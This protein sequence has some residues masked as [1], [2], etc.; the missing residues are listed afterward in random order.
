MD[1][2]N[3]LSNGGDYL[4][5]R[6]FLIG[7][8]LALAIANP[9]ESLAENHDWI[10]EDSGLII[11][12]TLKGAT[13]D[14]QNPL[15]TFTDDNPVLVASS[16]QELTDVIESQI[17]KMSE[18]ISIQYT[19]DVSSLS[20]QIGQIIRMYLTKNDYINGTVS[21]Y[22]YVYG[23][24]TKQAITINLSIS[25]LTTQTQE[26]FIQSEV[27]R[28][29]GEITTPTMS[30]FEKVKAVNDYIVLQSDYSYDT[31]TTP[32]SVYTLLN[33]GK[34]VCQA[35]ALL[36]YRLLQE[37]GMEVRYV[38]GWA[39]ELHAWNLVKVDGEWYH[40]DTTWNDP[41]FID[42]AVDRTDYISYKYFLIS[43]REI[44]KDHRI[45]K[46]NYPSATSDRFIAMRNVVTP[47]QI[48]NVLY[49][50]NVADDIKLYKIDFRKTPLVSEKISDIRVQYLFYGNDWL[51]F[52]NYSN[53]GYLYKMKLDGS[54]TVLLGN[55]L[56]TAIKQEQGD[57]VAYSN[58]EELYREVLQ[59]KSNP[60][61][62]Q[63]F[64]KQTSDLILMSNQ[65]NDQSERLIK[66]YEQLSSTE[67]LLIPVD[68]LSKFSIIEE[69]YKKMLSFT[70]ND[71][72]A[73]KE[74]RFIVDARKPWLIQLNQPV[75]NTHENLQH[76]AILNLFGE[77]I[78]V[79]IEVEEEIITVT[80]AENYEEKITYTL[81]IKPGLKNI[82]GKTLT[83]GVHQQFIYLPY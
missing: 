80:P 74:A 77:P 82:E 44:G 83:Q 61:L 27:K 15:L 4:I 81:I 1:F 49:F 18:F 65:F 71:T 72:I 7:A 53:R 41:I 26:V 46:L 42:S 11:N 36:A 14:V 25:Y 6:K 34:G 40:L 35:Y 73:H 69:K 56:V 62:V 76:V 37:V 54:T 19:G 50:P 31:I 28:I 59:Q 75:L 52:S 48:G 43:D 64:I 2:S 32:H 70:L 60:T 68:V 22:R 12:Q 16:L 17:G 30:E 66:L 9:S 79:S 10:I 5:T 29:A 20:D 8:I 58:D 63:Q 33:E 21:S 23:E 67:R 55:Q 39:G 45:D 24:I 78:D 47:I 57:I 38:T 13:I 51:Y 3:I